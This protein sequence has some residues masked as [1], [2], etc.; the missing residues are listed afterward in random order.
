MS[1][2]NSTHPILK[3]YVAIKAVELNDSIALKAA[4]LPILMQLMPMVNNVVKITELTGTC[5]LGW[6]MPN[7]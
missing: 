4:V 7:H 3:T 6:T 2:D 5:H 1:L